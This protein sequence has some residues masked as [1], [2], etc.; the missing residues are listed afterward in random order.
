MHCALLQV[1]RVANNIL[2]NNISDIGKYFAL[3]YTQIFTELRLVEL[4]PKFFKTLLPSPIS[5][6][7]NVIRPSF[8]NRFNQAF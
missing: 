5:S 6:L 8:F 7:K 4:K 2:K 3:F 1:L